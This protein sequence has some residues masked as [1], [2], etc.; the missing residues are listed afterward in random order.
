MNYRKDEIIEILKEETYGKLSD[1]QIEKIVNSLKGI[2]VEGILI[3]S[4]P[5][6]FDGNTRDD[7]IHFDPSSIE[8]YYSTARTIIGDYIS[9]KK[10]EYFLGDNFEYEMDL[11]ERG[12]KDSVTPSDFNMKE[13][14]VAI[15]EQE[16]EYAGIH[17]QK[18][19]VY[20]PDERNLEYD[21]YIDLYTDMQKKHEEERKK[22]FEELSLEVEKR[23][24][25]ES[26]EK[27]P[28][29]VL[30]SLLYDMGYEEIQQEGKK[31]NM[32][33]ENEKEK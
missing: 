32:N 8:M 20:I 6:K 33:K 24:A 16:N 31:V 15:L 29:D 3:A 9:G 28:P 14:Q 17:R 19:S 23:Q 11:M 30:K 21:R 1:E 22:Y 12:L 26:L 4:D 18:I 25:K 2:P 10:E 27:L 5:H 7:V 13:I